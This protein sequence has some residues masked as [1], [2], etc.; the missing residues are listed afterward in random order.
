VPDE[1]YAQ[2]TLHRLLQFLA[3]PEHMLAAGWLQQVIRA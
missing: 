1:G 2:V 3:Q